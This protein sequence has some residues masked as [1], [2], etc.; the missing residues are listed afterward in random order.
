MSFPSKYQIQ[1]INF[2]YTVQE[3]ICIMI[4]IDEKE[5]QL[6]SKIILF[7]SNNFDQVYYFVLAIICRSRTGT[8]IKYIR[9]KLCL[10]PC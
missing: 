8:T 7:Y 9:N 10:I 2:V 4:I 5:F 3:V 1:Q 6:K